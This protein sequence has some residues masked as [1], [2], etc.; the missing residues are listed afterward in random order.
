MADEKGERL[1]EMGS[2]FVKLNSSF[3]RFS[4]EHHY[5]KAE[6]EFSQGK[7]TRIRWIEATNKEVK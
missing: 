4:Q 7:I 3:V 6:V 2:R 5:A 1:E